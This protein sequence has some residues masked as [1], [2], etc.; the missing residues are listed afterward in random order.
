MTDIQQG[1]WIA[2]YSD[3]S[4]VAVFV[5]EIEALRHAVDGS[6]SVIW[7]RS[8]QTIAEAEAAERAARGAR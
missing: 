1:A 5:T 2:Y 6:M 8:G 7:V 4:A 3:M